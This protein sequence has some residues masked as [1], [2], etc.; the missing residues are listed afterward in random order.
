VLP[1][2]TQEGRPCHRKITFFRQCPGVT[3]IV[4]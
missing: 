1:K 3:L 2:A 4:A